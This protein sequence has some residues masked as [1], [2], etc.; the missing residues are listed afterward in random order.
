[1]V[2]ASGASL[3][4]RSPQQ[5]F[6]GDQLRGKDFP[7]PDFFVVLGVSP[8]ERKS[9]V[10]WD[11]E[12]GPDLIVEL[13]SDSTRQTARDAARQ[14]AEA[15]ARRAQEAERRAQDAEAEIARLR[16]LLGGAA[17]AANAGPGAGRYTAAGRQSWVSPWQDLHQAYR[18]S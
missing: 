10:V 17:P 1:M 3:P 8:R 4:Q 15:E 9:W 6:S 13:L 2:D 11:E 18:A 7:G 14:E 12:K 16:A 5:D